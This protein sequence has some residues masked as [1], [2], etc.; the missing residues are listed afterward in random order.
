MR[1]LIAGLLTAT[2]LA[3]SAAWARTV[4][5]P[6]GTRVFLE[7]ED[8]LLGKK[9]NVTIG[10]VVPSIVQRDVILDGAIVIPRG[11]TAF[12][13][14]DEFE[15]NRIAGRRG[16]IVL[17]AYEVQ[18]TGGVPLQLGGGYNKSGQSHVV[19]TAVLAGVV[20]WPLVFMKGKPAHLPPGTVFDAYVDGTFEVE[21]A[22]DAPVVTAPE[23]DP[24]TVEIL[25]DRLEQEKKAKYLHF[26]VSPVP[27]GAT[28]KVTE[29]NGYPVDPVIVEPEE[30]TQDG[31]VGSIKLK[32]ITKRLKPG[33]NEFTIRVED[34]TRRRIGRVLLDVQI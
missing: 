22:D 26:A 2:L 34:S 11:A 24:V 33:F 5:I 28:V 29:I 32:K 4:T 9:D 18:A 14:V 25:Y 31:F 16:K 15:K 21:I 6:D 30:A 19:R 23:P 27:A 13:K 17:G 8:D 3:P 20:L 1:R 7:T 10:Q 12:V